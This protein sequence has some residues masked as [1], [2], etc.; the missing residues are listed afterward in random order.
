MGLHV[1]QGGD[2]GQGLGRPVQLEAAEVEGARDGHARDALQRF[3][4]VQ[5][6]EG[7]DVLEAMT[8]T[9]PTALRF[10]SRACSRLSRKPVTTIASTSSVAAR[11]SAPGR[12]AFRPHWPGPRPAARRTALVIRRRTISPTPWP[13]SQ[14]R[15]EPL[16]Q[17]GA[18][19][20]EQDAAKIGQPGDQGDQRQEFETGPHAISALQHA[21]QPGRQSADDVGA[22]DDQARHGRA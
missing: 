14:T 8:S 9:A 18:A 12:H 2:H 16:G 19:A 11:R 1:E 15:V 3:R 17:R 4:Q 20:I 7:G 13:G 22:G 6:W 5:V 10:G 21:H